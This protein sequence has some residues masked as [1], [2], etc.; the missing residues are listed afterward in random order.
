MHKFYK[1]VFPNYLHKTSQKKF[2]HFFLQTFYFK[3]EFAKE[4]LIFANLQIFLLTL[5][6]EHKSF[7]MMYNFSY[8]DIKQWVLEGKGE[9]DNPPPYRILVF[10][11]TSRE[12][13][14]SRILLQQSGLQMYCT[15]YL[16]A[17]KSFLFV[18]SASNQ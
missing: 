8:L 4:R 1:E 14:N 9:I 16:K 3:L 10:K 6:V 2:S 7:P 12:R 15:L 18:R 5:K 17:W 13:V 11:Y